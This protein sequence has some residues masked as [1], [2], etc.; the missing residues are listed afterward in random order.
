MPAQTAWSGLLQSVELLA[1]CSD[2][3]PVLKS[4][5]GGLAAFMKVAQVGK[6]FIQLY[7]PRSS[8]QSLQNY[9][10][11][12]EEIGRLKQNVDVAARIIQKYQAA[13]RSVEMEECLQTFSKYVKLLPSAIN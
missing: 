1:A 2:W 12:P 8:T 7:I 13:A 4:A 9:V 10:N 3:N 6:Y 11:T 5:S